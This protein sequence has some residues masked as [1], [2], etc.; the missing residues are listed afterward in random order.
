M[1]VDVFIGCDMSQDT[2]DYCIRNR[3]H[4]LQEGQIQN[5]PAQIRSWLKR[6]QRTY[7]PTQ[8]VLGLEH[9]GMYS[10]LL[11]R[12]AHAQELH[13]CVEHAMQI[14]F[15]L[16]LQRGKS[17][18]V[19]AQ[20]IAEYLMRFTDRLKVWKPKREVI[21]QL[22]AL[23]RNRE[24]LLKVRKQLTQHLPAA[25]RFLTRAEWTIEQRACQRTVQTVDTDIQQL[26][27]EI[28]TLIQQDT[29][30][31]ALRGYVTSVV[32]VGEVT[33]VELVLRTNEFKDFAN[34][35]QLA[36]TAGVA[37]F[38]YQ[39]GSSLAG[40]PRVSHRAHK[41]LK[42]LLHLCAMAAI[43]SPGELQDYYL[44]KVQEG[45]AKMS[46]LNAV[47]NKLVHRIFAVATKQIMYQRNY[48]YALHKP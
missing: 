25:K 12:E 35:K 24:R 30:L 15:S 1:Q 42:T 3:T 31:R 11:L 45:K 34:A 37:P 8:L 10:A 7:A 18:R 48:Q 14:K 44:R 9:T 26:S 32:G 21:L 38:Q 43:K 27:Q 23:Q 17:D 13:V 39:S 40:R 4:L 16:G 28:H 6:L 19:D 29:H 47:R 22:Q 33:F 41:R 5:K 2:F 36:C 20:R 46:V